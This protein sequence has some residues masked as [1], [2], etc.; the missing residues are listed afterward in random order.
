V[1]Y[2]KGHGAM[3]FARQRKYPLFST[4]QSFIKVGKFTAFT[5]RPKRVSASEVGG[6]WLGDSW[7]L[8]PLNSAGA[9]PPDPHYRLAFRRLP[10]PPFAKS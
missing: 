6:A 8:L 2:L 5:E 10:W 9:P 1:T 3:P 4:F 7:A